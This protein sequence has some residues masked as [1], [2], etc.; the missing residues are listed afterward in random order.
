[1]Q[2]I[3]LR[4]FIDNDINTLKKYKFNKLS[5]EEIKELILEWNSKTINGNYFEMFAILNDDNVVGTISVYQSSENMCSCGVE[6][7]SDYRRQ[8]F[9]REAM[10]IILNELRDRGIKLVC[11]QIRKNNTASILL[12]KSLKFETDGYIYTNKKGNEVLIYFKILI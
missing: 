3:K 12:H 7:Y 8:G 9:G 6:V 5:Q 4:N 10:I 1:M 11:Q 2:M